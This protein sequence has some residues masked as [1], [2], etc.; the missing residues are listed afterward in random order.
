MQLIAFQKERLKNLNATITQM[1]FYFSK[2]YYLVPLAIQQYDYL[3]VKIPVWAC[4]SINYQMEK[5][6]RKIQLLFWY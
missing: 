4:F 6:N 3:I 1:R 2:Y 5:H